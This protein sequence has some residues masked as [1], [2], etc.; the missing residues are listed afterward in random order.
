MAHASRQ[1]SGLDYPCYQLNITRK[2]LYSRLQRN[3]ESLLKWIRK[4]KILQEEAMPE[5]VLR[6]ISATLEPSIA[7]GK[8]DYLIEYENMH[9]I[10][11]SCGRVG[12]W[13]EHCNQVP[14]P[15]KTQGEPSVTVN[16]QVIP[17]KGPVKFNG[18]I[19]VT[20][21][22]E[23]G[24]SEWMVVT[25]R[26]KPNRPTGPT[27]AE[28]HNFQQQNYRAKDHFNQGTTDAN[29]PGT[30]KAHFSNQTHAKGLRNKNYVPKPMNHPKDSPPPQKSPNPSFGPRTTKILVLISN[31]VLRP[32]WSSQPYQ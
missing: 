18:Q 31:L 8:Y 32:I 1:Q 9:V 20:G 17:D 25:H 26:K 23:I 28:A 21:P 24:Y 3:W 2:T 22:Q 19:D 30:S 14:A 11:F 15:E 7:V 4:W 6:W 13:R 5:C 27:R 16:N 10:C 12:H 29:R